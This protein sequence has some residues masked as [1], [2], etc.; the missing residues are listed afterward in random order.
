LI[1]LVLYSIAELFML[2]EFAK[3]KDKLAMKSAIASP[4]FLWLVMIAGYVYD[5]RIPGAVFMLGVLSA[6]ANSYLGYYR[7]LY[8]RSRKFDRFQH[9]FGSFSA[10]LF[11][12]FLLGNL[13]EYGGSRAFGAF[14]VLLLGIFC[15]TVH[16]IG[17]FIADLRGAEKMQKGLRDTNM[18]MVSNLIGSALACAAA[19][20]F[21]I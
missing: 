8:N 2:R 7:D 9:A 21:V 19:Y 6:F 13:F 20:F 15:G 5:F 18:D 3:R 10:A 1:L 4:L 16:E 14:Y 11:F 12:Y 17:E